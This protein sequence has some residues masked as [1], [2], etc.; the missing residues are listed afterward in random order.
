MAIGGPDPEWRVEPGLLPYL[1]AVAA[2]TA[3]VDAIA[4]GTAPEHIW[5]VEHPPVITAGTSADLADLR[6]PDRFPLFNSGRGGQL[7]YH[8]PGQRVVYVLLDLSRRGRDVRT[9]VRRL[10]GWA[11]AALAQLG[12]AAFTSPTGTGIWVLRDG[13]EAKIGAIGIRVRRWVSFHGLA[14]NVT[15]DLDHF[16]AIVPCGIVDRGV[17]RLADLQPGTTM[18]DLDQALAAT[19][20]DFLA[21][22]SPRGPAG[23]I[24]LEGAVECR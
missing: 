10:E 4:A 16:E 21:G 19:L 8:G 7:T 20:P 15:T 9:F 2:M 18:T 11:I 5:L 1:Q 22:L 3:R 17:A 14:I 6:Q 24:A 12:V 23:T 13:R